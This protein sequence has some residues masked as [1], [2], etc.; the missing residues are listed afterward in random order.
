MSIDA[1]YIA[2]KHNV[3]NLNES[4][5]NS[6]PFYV[7]ESDIKRLTA[8]YRSTFPNESFPPKFHMLEDHIVSFIR[9]WKFPCG[10]FGVQG[11]ESIHHEFVA[12]QNSFNNVHPVTKRYKG[13]L[14]R[15]FTNVYPESR[16][17]IPEKTTRSLK[18]KREI[19]TVETE[20][21]DLKIKI[22]FC[23]KIYTRERSA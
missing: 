15:H 18:R 1:F 5:L 4:K 21:N 22:N 9:K 16:K 14:E 13:M 7:T 8:Y 19:K 6:K 10:F 20:K 17:S 23:F 2:S 3:N 11:G 12:L